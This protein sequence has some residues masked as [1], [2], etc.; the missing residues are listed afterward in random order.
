M[1]QVLI[2]ISLLIIAQLSVGLMDDV[3]F[4]YDTSFPAKKEWREDF[5]KPVESWKG[6]YRKDS[7]GALIA[8]PENWY[9]NS[10]DISYKEKFPLS[11]TLFVSFTDAWHLLKTISEACTRTVIVLLGI[12]LYGSTLT[13]KRKWLYGSAA[14]VAI[15]IIQSL[16]FHLTYTLL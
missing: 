13:A 14:W 15:F 11:A 12:W 2:I 7:E 16:S 6:K 9:Y 8:A 3:N 10:F 5:W 1:K 4:H